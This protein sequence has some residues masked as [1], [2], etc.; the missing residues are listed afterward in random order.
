ML[1]I[2]RD[3]HVDSKTEEPNL[4]KISEI[5]SCF[6]VQIYLLEQNLN[7]TKRQRIVY[8]MYDRIEIPAMLIE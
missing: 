7:K 4:K 3:N 8:E 5:F 1:V 2:D 6:F